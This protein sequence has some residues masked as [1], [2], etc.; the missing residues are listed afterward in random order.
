MRHSWISGFIHLSSSSKEYTDFMLF[1]SLSSASGGDVCHRHFACWEIRPTIRL[2]GHTFLMGVFCSGELTHCH[3]NCHLCEGFISNLFGALGKAA[4]DSRW[5]LL[6]TSRIAK[7]K[8]VIFG[9]GMPGRPLGGQHKQRGKFQLSIRNFGWNKILI[10]FGRR[11]N[12]SHLLAD[13]LS[14]EMTPAGIERS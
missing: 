6:K 1:C 12:P 7:R 13:G 3:W 2:L 10:F 4:T 9:H 8:W 5:P 14:P 11:K